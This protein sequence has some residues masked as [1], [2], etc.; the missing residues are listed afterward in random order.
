[1]AGSSYCVVGLGLLAVSPVCPI[2][3]CYL[4]SLLLVLWSLLLGMDYPASKVGRIRDRI[5]S[6]GVT[7]R[8]S[9]YSTG[10]TVS[11]EGSGTI[12]SIDRFLLHPMYTIS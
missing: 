5:A 12:A 2:V 4:T 9:E 1:M 7:R 3:H 8:C 11:D 10:Q 6:G